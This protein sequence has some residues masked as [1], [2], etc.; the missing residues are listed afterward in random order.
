MNMESTTNM[1][2]NNRTRKSLGEIPAV[3]LNPMA[4]IHNNVR[5]LERAF[6]NCGD[7]VRL[8][9]PVGPDAVFSRDVDI[10]REIYRTQT[11]KSKFIVGRA[12]HAMGQGIFAQ[13]GGSQWRSKRHVVSKA[14]PK[15]EDPQIKL[16]A[17][18]PCMDEFIAQLAAEVSSEAELDVR[19][20]VSR[21]IADYSFRAFFSAD[22]GDNASV[23]A[24]AF[25]Y[26]M[27]NFLDPTPLWV[28]TAA[29]I[30]FKKS[31]RKLR[32]LMRSVVESRT[33][34]SPSND[35]LG[36]LRK[37]CTTE[38]TIDQMISIF[39]GTSVLVGSLVW[40]LYCVARN[41]AVN[42]RLLSEIDDTLGD[43]K[44]TPS[45]IE[46]L[47]Y[48]KMIFDE[49]LRLYP[50]AWTTPRVCREPFHVDE[51][52]IPSGTYLFP[53][54]YFLHRNEKYWEHPETFDPERFS[55]DQKHRAY[56]PFGAGGRMCPGATLAPLIAR[57]VLIRLAQQ[58]TFAP[59]SE[60]SAKFGFELAP[61]SPITLLL[62]KRRLPTPCLPV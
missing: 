30:K 29:N 55:D 38:D 36:V 56:L 50:A 11:Y 45:D 24:D 3:R 14:F 40:M 37:N 33:A 47:E 41:P 35:V 54:V 4:S 42:Q 15:D 27:D 51:Y 13:I 39:S 53:M 25:H 58:F 60:N 12:R 32:T 49:T 19:Q 62:K 10:V 5:K 1:V 16:A 9:N 34:E 61:A 21:F 57:Y 59:S 6:D 23:A 43:R 20:H 44:A 31:V 26:L 8:W 18:L 46:T 52:S 22:I 2:N 28:P 48:P 7:T 17:I